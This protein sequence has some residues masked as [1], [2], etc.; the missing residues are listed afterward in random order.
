MC[1]SKG[2][3]CTF[4]SFQRI[5]AFLQSTAV[6]S[7]GDPLWCHNNYLALE[8]IASN[9]DGFYAHR[10]KR[11]KVQLILGSQVNNVSHLNPEYW[12][13]TSHQGSQ[14]LACSLT[15]GLR[16]PACCRTSFWSRDWQHGF[17]ESLCRTPS[18]ASFTNRAATS[19]ISV[20]DLS[21]SM[22][23]VNSG[24]RK[25]NSDPGKVCLVLISTLMQSRVYSATAIIHTTHTCTVSIRYWNR[26][27]IVHD[28]LKSIWHNV[29]VEFCIRMAW[30]G[31]FFLVFSSLGW[32]AGSICACRTTRRGPL[33]SP[34]ALN[35]V[36]K[37]WNCQAKQRQQRQRRMP[38]RT[39]GSRA[40]SRVMALQN[41]W[42]DCFCTSIEKFTSF[43]RCTVSVYQMYHLSILSLRF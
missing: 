26:V 41:L 42:R 33:T 7:L 15:L 23:R 27:K 17:L 8:V 43:D 29:N 21:Q 16:Y 24:S 37:Q 36:T 31:R 2:R 6:S 14:R 12:Q 10:C 11:E 3:H 22:F 20:S 39:R 30:G 5:E 13:W 40:L 38:R 35:G 1:L 9:S 19:F 4:K 32:S 34:N 18:S 28:K 25:R